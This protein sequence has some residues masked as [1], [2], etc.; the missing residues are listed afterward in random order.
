MYSKEFK[1][2]LKYF[3]KTT[4]LQIDID[5]TRIPAVAQLPEDFAKERPIEFTFGDKKEWK[6]KL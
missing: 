6:N 1:E 4:Y 5:G 3:T 2:P